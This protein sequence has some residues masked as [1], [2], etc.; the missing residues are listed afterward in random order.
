MFLSGQDSRFAANKC[1]WKCQ[2]CLLESQRP[3][4]SPGTQP[5]CKSLALALPRGWLHS[6]FAISRGLLSP[7]PVS[8]SSIHTE[9]TSLGSVLQSLFLLLVYI[10][11]FWVLCF[12]TVGNTFIFLHCRGGKKMISRKSYSAWPPWSKKVL[13]KGCL[14]SPPLWYLNGSWWGRLLPCQMWL[15]VSLFDQH[16]ATLHL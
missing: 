13:F 7:L 9:P 14:L 11:P 1:F 15:N 8:A 16:D 10:F 3:T 2:I 12:H 4:V 6:P 5:R